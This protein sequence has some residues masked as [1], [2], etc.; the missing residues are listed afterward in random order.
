ML[1]L[2]LLTALIPTPVLVRPADWSSVFYVVSQRGFRDSRFSWLVSGFTI[3]LCSSCESRSRSI[4]RSSTSVY[5][6][7]CRWSFSCRFRPGGNYSVPKIENIS[8]TLLKNG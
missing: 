1:H 5:V 3:L 6:C 7:P 8:I 4:V 2:G